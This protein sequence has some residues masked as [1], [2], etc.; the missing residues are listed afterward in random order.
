[1]IHEPPD[2]EVVIVTGSSGL[3]GRALID[4]LRSTYQIAGFDLDGEPQPPR[5]VE[6]ICVDLTDDESVKRGVER[7]RF[8][9]GSRV[10]SVVHLAAYYDFSGVESDLY[11]KVTVRG[12]ERLLSHLQDLEVEQFL[13]SS[14]ML[15]HEPTKPGAPITE[16]SPLLP[17][18]P[19]P[20]SKVRTE[21]LI[22]AER[23]SI[24]AVILRIAGVYTDSC[25]SLPLSHQIQRI[26]ERRLSSHVYPGE[27]S[28]G[29]LAQIERGAEEPD[30]HIGPGVDG[31]SHAGLALGHGH[32]SD[33]IG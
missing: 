16:N 7:V 17:R 33:T 8:A 6:C 26:V 29:A 3:I 24:P 30:H 12:T 32:S 2:K 20:R 28:H 25:D 14:T 19:Y 9:Y 13:F 5:E 31:G 22:A 21:E 10:A 4:N 11:E 27:L 18:W 23:G 15:V 1:M